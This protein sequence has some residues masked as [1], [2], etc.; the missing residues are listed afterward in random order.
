MALMRIGL[1]GC[2]N[3]ASDICLAIR[4]KAIPAE[5]VALRDIDMSQ[6]E[7]LRQEY[8]LNAFI[9]TLDELAAAVDFIVE[10]AVPAV[11]PEV[12]RVAIAHRVDCL[13]MS[14]GGLLEHPELVDAA[15]SHNVTLRIPSGAVCGMDG[16]RV[17]MQAGLDELT[18]TTSKPPKGLKGAPYL[19]E[20]GITLDNLAEPLVVFDGTA[21]EAVKAFP[22]NIN[23]A[24]ALSLAGP[25][26]DKTQVRIVADPNTTVNTHEIHATGPF[27]ELT[28]IMR[29]HPSPR[30]PKSS[31][32]ASLSACAEVSA[33]AALFA[34]RT[35]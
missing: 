28:A 27:G 15:R 6:A 22:A 26:P 24:A 9:G 2:G 3:I 31:Y 4:D 32:M 17:A 30:N 12:V 25:G 13:V 11:V 5:V 35:G 21:R 19:V 29:N 18:L 7:S 10:C 34:A 8:K 20:R 16:I 14:L 33:A 1:V 23:V